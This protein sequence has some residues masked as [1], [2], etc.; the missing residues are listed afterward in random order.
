MY[1]TSRQLRYHTFFVFDADPASSCEIP[2][3]FPPTLV[4][5]YCSRI[6]FG[7]MAEATVC[8]RLLCTTCGTTCSRGR[9]GTGAGGHHGAGCWGDAVPSRLPS[10]YRHGGELD[11]AELKASV[12]QATT[13]A[14][15]GVQFVTGQLANLVL[16]LEIVDSGSPQ[17]TL[18]P[19]TFVGPCKVAK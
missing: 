13:Q 1:T 12:V 5:I 7:A 18:P 6:L 15:L 9:W 3:V 8:F 4:V 10:I 11:T 14:R 19:K 16:S 17:D 2:F